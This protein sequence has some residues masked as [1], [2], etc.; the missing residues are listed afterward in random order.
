MLYGQA[1]LSSTQL[2]CIA[3]LHCASLNTSLVAALGPHL[4]QQYYADAIKSEQEIVFALT[5][6][7][8]VKAACLV[9]KDPHSLS[10]RFVK[11]HPLLMGV[12]FVQGLLAG[13]KRRNILLGCFT[14]KEPYPEEVRALPELVQIFTDPQF[15]NQKLGTSLLE[16]IET[17]L[18]GQGYAAYFIKTSAGV[19]NDAL[20]FYSKRGFELVETIEDRVFL[21]KRLA[22]SEPQH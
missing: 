20:H 22:V 5:E 15:R 8:Q 6:D 9:S 14:K 12:S 1:K 16:Q 21:K 17:C 7:E 13:A 10:K 11:R 19:G 4:T 2:K 18:S 3:R